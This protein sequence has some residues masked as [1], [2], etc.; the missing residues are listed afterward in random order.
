MYKYQFLNEFRHSRNLQCSQI[1]YTHC[2]VV[3]FQFMYFCGKLKET[4]IKNNFNQQY[5][6]RKMRNK[7]IIKIQKVEL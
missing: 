7:I 5:K 1:S 4:I 2:D 6:F 3:K